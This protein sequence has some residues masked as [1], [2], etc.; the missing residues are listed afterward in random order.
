MA[1]T[2]QPASFVFT[3]FEMA[4]ESTGISGKA[5]AVILSVL[6]SQY[7]LY[8]YD[9]AAHLTEETKVADKNGPIA[10]LSG[11]G[12]SQYLDGLIFWPSLSAFR[13]ASNY[14]L[15]A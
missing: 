11:I 1:L 3:R 9:A 6:V 14:R 15:D 8:G 4:P 2:T 13:L 7:S 10:I 5:Y 12:S